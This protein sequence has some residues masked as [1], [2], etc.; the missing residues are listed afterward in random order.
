ME[1]MVILLPLALGLGLAF[2]FFFIW[3]VKRGQYDDLE[4]PKHRMLIDEEVKLVN[5]RKKL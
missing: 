2:V 1:I 3:A 5:K 4:T